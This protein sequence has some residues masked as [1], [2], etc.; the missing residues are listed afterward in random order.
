M[1]SIILFIYAVLL[2]YFSTFFFVSAQTGEQVSVMKAQ[3]TN[4]LERHEETLPGI[5]TR[6]FLQTVEAKIITGKDAGRIIVISEDYLGLSEGDKFYLEHIVNDLDSTDLWVIRERDRTPLLVLLLAIFVGLVFLVGGK[7]GI[8][9]V[10]SLA[11]SI[12]IIIFIYI[13]LILRGY[14]PLFLSVLIAGAITV[15]AAYV[16]HGFRRSTSAAVI[17][18]LIAVILSAFLAKIVIAML[19]MT[20]V[21]S[22][23]EVYLNYNTG[24]IIDFPGLLLG[25]VL[26][27]LLGVLYDAAIGQSVAVE[28]L[29][30][31][32]PKLEPHVAFLRA[33]RIGREH[34]GAL[35]NMLALAYV[36]TS[37]P[38]LLLFSTSEY[39]IGVTFSHEEIVA[40]MIRMLIGGIGVL[41]VVPL[42]TVIAVAML[43]PR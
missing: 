2:T 37:L 18:M 4:V 30:H 21:T 38:L 26:I 5:G 27:G 12:V 34:I 11:G 36:G 23:S 29:F 22:E 10:V 39:P 43:R 40:E 28:E 41:F 42:A 32:A 1:K 20:G 24:G 35:V 6:A 25:G 15:V 17:G 19:G 3:V 13:P 8:R 7:Q 33:L 14:P 16:T 9:G 31:V